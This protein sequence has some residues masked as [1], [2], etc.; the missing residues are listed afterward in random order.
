MILHICIVKVKSYLNL[1]KTQ[2]KHINR[3][4]LMAK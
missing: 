4:M 3:D 1:K 2:F